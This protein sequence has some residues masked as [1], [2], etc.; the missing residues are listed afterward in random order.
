MNDI[1]I[2][3]MVSAAAEGDADAPGGRIHALIRAVAEHCAQIADKNPNAGEI[4]R[5][6]FVYPT[7]TKTAAAARVASLIKRA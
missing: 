4:I 5:Q 6:K 1:L 2:N 3:A 7:P